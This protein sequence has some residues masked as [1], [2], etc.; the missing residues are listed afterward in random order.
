MKVPYICEKGIHINN[1]VKEILFLGNIKKKNPNRVSVS[2]YRDRN[3]C[4]EIQ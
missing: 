1:S 2:K 3:Y 4:S